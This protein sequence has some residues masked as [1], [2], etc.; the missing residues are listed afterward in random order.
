[1]GPPSS[2]GPRADSRGNAPSRPGRVAAERSSRT[3]FWLETDLHDRC[4]RRRDRGEPAAGEA[5]LLDQRQPLGR[6][7]EACQRGRTRNLD[8]D[9][10]LEGRL[11]FMG[12]PSRTSGVMKPWQPAGCCGS[13]VTGIGV[14]SVPRPSTRKGCAICCAEEKVE[15]GPEYVI[16]NDVPSTGRPWLPIASGWP[17]KAQPVPNGAKAAD[18]AASAPESRRRER[19]RIMVGGKRPGYATAQP[20]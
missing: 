19:I 7:Q 8:G 20:A 10:V 12:V 5:T 16:W 1:M 13:K 6:E 17:W 18:W 14:T 4:V 15:L 2:Q 9:E 3:G 11:G